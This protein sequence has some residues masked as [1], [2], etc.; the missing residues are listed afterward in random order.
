MSNFND[1]QKEIGQIKVEKTLEERA[2]GQENESVVTH[3]LV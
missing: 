2:G 1:K 3:I